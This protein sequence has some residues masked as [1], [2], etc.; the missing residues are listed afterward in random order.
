[1]F[2]LKCITQLIF[3]LLLGCAASLPDK[4]NPVPGTYSQVMDMRVGLFRRSYVVHVP[5]SYDGTKAVPLVVLLHGAFGTAE[6]MAQKTGFNRL[7][8][9]EGFVAVYAN[10]MTLFG[11]LQHWNGG[12]CCGRAHAIQLDDVAYLEKVIREVRDH[13]HI[14][15]HRIY[16][17]GNSNGGMLA[18]RFAA[19]RSELIAAA[20]VVAGTLGGKPSGEKAEWRPPA[21]REPTSIIVI[22]GKAD[23]KIPYNG[24]LDPTTDSGRTHISVEES[25]RFWVNHNRCNREPT[26]DRLFNGRVVRKTWGNGCAPARVSLYALEGWGHL[27]P[28]PHV[29]VTPRENPVKN[30]DAAEIIWHFF[31]MTTRG[32]P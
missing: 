17:V 26:V 8:D 15:Q 14:D 12:H 32:S 21:P 31:K 28:G 9:R 3:L 6:G 23:R 4:G 5:K 29:T 19:E 25:V 22:H 30:F 24:G 11:W 27:W 7:A 2:A 16:V 18:H 13:L 20:A 10:G 1:M